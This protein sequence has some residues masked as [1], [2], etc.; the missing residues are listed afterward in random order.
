MTILTINRS[1][2]FFEQYVKYTNVVVIYKELRTK[3]L[4][5][6]RQ[7]HLKSGLPGYSIW[8][9]KEFKALRYKNNDSVIF[10]D[11]ALTLPAVNYLSKTNKSLRIIYWFWKGIKNGKKFNWGNLV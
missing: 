9:T 5:A 3:I 11:T 6:I 1:V 7:I 2:Q 8:Y 4:K 10:F